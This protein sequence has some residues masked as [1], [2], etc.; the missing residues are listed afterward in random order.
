[1]SSL[2]GVC[3]Q[4][5]VEV[6][7]E[8]PQVLGGG[9]VVVLQDVLDCHSGSLRSCAAFGPRATCRRS[10]GIF[11]ARASR[12]SHNKQRQREERETACRAKSPLVHK[13]H[14]QRQRYTPSVLPLPSPRLSP[15]SCPNLHDG[16]RAPARLSARPFFRTLRAAATSTYSSRRIA[17]PGIREIAPPQWLPGAASMIAASPRR[18]RRP[19]ALHARRDATRPGTRRRLRR[20]I[21]PRLARPRKPAS[22]V[23]ASTF[24]SPPSPPRLSCYP[25]CEWVVAN[26]D[27]LHTLRR[28]LPSPPCSVTARMNGGGVPPGP[29]R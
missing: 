21:L 12:R 27:R 13:S 19:S 14:P 28:S 20:R 10:A 5:G 3:R 29:A 1:M 23:M 22:P 11:P 26:A 18:W 7:L 24:P 25:Q 9:R 17:A 16:W 6:G 15:T 8:A 2:V 4:V